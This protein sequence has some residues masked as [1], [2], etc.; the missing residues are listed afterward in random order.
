MGGCSRPRSSSELATSRDSAGIRIVVS[1][2]PDSASDVVAVLDSQPLLVLGE[3]DGPADEQFGRRVDARLLADAVAVLDPRNHRIVL[4]GFDG[5]LRRSIGQEGEGPGDMR[6]A[7]RFLLTAGDSLVIW[8]YQLD[9]VTTFDT[10]GSVRAVTALAKVEPNEEQGVRYTSSQNPF[11]RLADG[12]FVVAAGPFRINPPAGVHHDSLMY[13]LI[14]TT[15]V[16]DTLVQRAAGANWSY[17]APS[18]NIWFDSLPYAPRAADVFTDSAWYRIDGDRFEI[19]ARNWSSEVRR[20]IRSLRARR[21]VT[22]ADKSRSRAEQVAAEDAQYRAELSLAYEWLPYPDSMPAYDQLVLDATGV[23]WARVFPDTTAMATWD[24]FGA[25]GT[26][27]GI[28][29][30]PSNLRIRDITVD[31]VLAEHSGELG[32]VQVRLYRLTRRVH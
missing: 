32:E 7:D 24:L 26:L 18:G 14:D 20:M 9:R 28:A 27:T 17:E 29:R 12:R 6:Q 11:F 13:S 19:T 1:A 4:F 5:T 30:M 16:T 15:G 3:L 8:D 23:L 25:D 22:E 31:R 10:A 2:V 21:P